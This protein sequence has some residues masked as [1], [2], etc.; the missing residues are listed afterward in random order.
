MTDNE[1]YSLFQKR[2][3]NARQAV[4]EFVAMI[5]EA[6][7]RKIYKKKGF[8]SI[9]ELAAKVGG[10]SRNVVD[11]A[12]R[13]DEKLK[14]M[15]KL[16]SKIAVVGLSKVKTV[17]NTATKETDNEW[18]QKVT[19]MTRSALETHAR[20]V[21]NS[22]PGESKPNTQQESIFDNQVEFETF[23]IK[24]DP[25]MVIKLKQLKNKM[26]KGT[27]WNEVFENLLPKEPKPQKNP[28]PASPK[29]RTAS[30][31]KRRDALNKT[32]GLCSISGCNK[33]ATEIH[34]KKPWAIFKKHDELEPHCKGHHELAH[35]S[36][37]AI[38][39]KFRAYK[40]QAA[41]F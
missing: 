11:E 36:E 39:K 8:G 32:K 19:K 40:M 7:K 25:K 27:T 12:L 15:P 41:L 17:A 37:S 14:E 31:Q 9:Y 34:H 1:F 16:K 2:G 29:S 33:P 21:R 26:P 23:S 13:I 30:T 28:R 5:P 20:D 35:Q 22:L 6:F 38:D 24:L 3:K 4:N 18:A 10:L